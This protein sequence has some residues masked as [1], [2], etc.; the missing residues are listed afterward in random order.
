M[1]ISGSENLFTK[2][3]E[4]LSQI[5]EE[6]SMA[7]V[8]SN[9][10]MPRNGDQYYPFR[11]QSDFY[12]L[13]GIREPE[14]IVLIAPSGSWLFLREPSEQT[15][16]WEGAQPTEEEAAAI[17]GITRVQW[18]KDFNKILE[19]EAASS[20]KLYLNLPEKLA[21]GL[22]KSRDEAFLEQFRS[23][24]PF[25]QIQSLKPL[26]KRL[27]LSKEPEEIA[28]IQKAIDITGKAFSRVL[29]KVKPGIPEKSIEA[30]IIHELIINQ[31]E[32]F[33]FDPIVASGKNATTLHYSQNKD[34]CREGE[35]LLMDFGA[36]YQYYAA[37]ITRTIPVNGRFSSR[38][39]DCYQAVLDVMNQTMKQ[40]R[41]GMSLYELNLQVQ[42][43][44]AAK[45]IELGLY[46][47]N[48]LRN[49]DSPL[50][51]KYFP[52]GVSHFMGLDV[53]DPGDK[54]TILE[55]G[56]VISWEP[57][58]YIPEEGI[59]IRIE[60]DILVDDHP[61]NL[62]ASIPRSPEEIETLMQNTHT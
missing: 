39:K 33:A 44:L 30:E 34:T 15:A 6:G 55:K 25:H 21:G 46:T 40:I 51:K 18:L 38:Q 58:L 20:K 57:G 31:A 24:Y 60:D 41:P 22:I 19:K 48:E 3:R 28:A 45:H 5:M 27:R 14:G 4:K 12:Y 13:T 8:F 11:Q 54:H 50:W 23:T 29:G 61:V 62:S 52:H 53:H 35:L 36:E 26:I 56:M 1:E 43:E 32:G 42:E 2:N 49:A 17:S 7:V 16:L 47:E 59:G 37:D 10:R 9:Q